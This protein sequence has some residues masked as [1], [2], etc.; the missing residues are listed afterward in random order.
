MY[1]KGGGGVKRFKHEI[2]GQS[3]V[4][5]YYDWFHY[6]GLGVYRIIRWFSVDTAKRF[7]D[8]MYPRCIRYEINGKKVSV[9]DFR[10]LR[11]REDV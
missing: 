1:E 8:W 5:T 7:D 10:E 4:M 11:K 6:V 2:D 9:E 3:L